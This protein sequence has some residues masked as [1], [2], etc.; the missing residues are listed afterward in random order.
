VGTWSRGK[1]Q[2]LAVAR[3]SC[4]VLR[5]TFWY[6]PTAGH[7]PGGLVGPAGGS[8]H[9]AAREEPRVPHAHNLVD[10]EACAAA[11]P[12]SVRPSGWRWAIPK[13]RGRLQRLIESVSGP[14]FSLE[15]VRGRCRSL[16]VE[17]L[18]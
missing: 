10:A 12:S 6:E 3:A 9:L 2:K 4:T 17:E 11:S 7:D 18:P 13:L 14:G 15:V 16:Q 5:S 1:K 8:G